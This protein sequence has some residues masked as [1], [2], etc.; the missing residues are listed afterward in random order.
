MIQDPNK[1]ARLNSESD[2][3]EDTIE[4]EGLRGTVRGL[5]S[6]IGRYKRQRETTDA[7]TNN[8]NNN[9]A[10]ASRKSKKK[11]KRKDGIEQPGSGYEYDND[12]LIDGIDAWMR[13]WKDAEEGSRVRARMRKQRRE[14]RRRRKA[15]R[16]RNNEHVH[17]AG[18]YG[19]R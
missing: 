8:N 2:I 5:E 4:L 14:L 7:Q 10:A 19:G 18:G 9:H 11:N 3:F 12:A 17:V 6:W 13:G 16:G 1:T 15:G